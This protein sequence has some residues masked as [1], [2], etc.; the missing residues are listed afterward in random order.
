MTAKKKSS[1]LDKLGVDKLFVTLSAIWILSAALL[2]FLWRFL[3][4]NNQLPIYTPISVF[5][6]QYT[7]IV[8]FVNLVLAVSIIRKSAS[9]AHLLLFV[10]VFINLLNIIM[11]VYS[12]RFFMVQ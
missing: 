10:A 7:L 2:F 5:P 11:V 6:F 12:Y 9:I 1:Y 4:Q 3:I 8:M